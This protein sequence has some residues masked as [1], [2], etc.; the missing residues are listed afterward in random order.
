MK[1]S[2][3]YLWA[4]PI[5]IYSLVSYPLS[6]IPDSHGVFLLILGLLVSI[7]A[8]NVA[9]FKHSA[10]GPFAMFLD[11]EKF[12]KFELS[13]SEQA[14]IAIG[15]VLTLASVVSMGLAVLFAEACN[16]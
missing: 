10:Y 2:R 14:L 13:K 4:L 9:L 6:F 15:L 11:S 1:M 7:G 3:A 12:S 8:Y 5:I 16:G